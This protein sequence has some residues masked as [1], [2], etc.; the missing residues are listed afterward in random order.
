MTSSYNRNNDII[1]NKTFTIDEASYINMLKCRH[2][3]SRT[4]TSFFLSDFPPLDTKLLGLPI[5]KTKLTGTSHYKC[6]S[7][8]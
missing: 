1:P 8:S 5:Y 3:S 6:Y 4:V 7:H 2:V